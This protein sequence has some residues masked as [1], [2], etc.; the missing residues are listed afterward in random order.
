MKRRKANVEPSV[1]LQALD[2]SFVEVGASFGGKKLKDF[3]TFWIFAL[4]TIFTVFVPK[5]DTL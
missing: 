3:L 2:L 1:G 4:W 5:T